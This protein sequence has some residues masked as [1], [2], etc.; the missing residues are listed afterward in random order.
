MT[1][2]LSP[3]LHERFFAVAERRPG[4]PAIVDEHGTATYGELA[5]D[6]V[7][8]RDL[9]LKAA[10]DDERLIA[11]RAGRTR[12]AIAAMIGILAA[13]RGYVPIDPDYPSARRE[14]L[15][16]DSGTRL[17]LTDAPGADARLDSW[18]GLFLEAV[19]R[20]PSPSVPPGTA[21]VIYTSG[22]TGDPK[23]CVV[24]HDNVLALLDASAPLFA[25]GPGDV[26][27]VL[28]SFSFDF[29]VWEIWAALLF[30]GTAVLLSRSAL[31]DPRELMGSLDD[32]G[33]TRLSATPSLF[34]FLVRE[35]ETRA[36]SLPR[37]RSVV[38]GGEPIVPSDVASWLDRA[39]APRA[40]VVNMY[41][42]TETTVHVTYCRLDAGVLAEFDEG[43]PIGRPLPHLGISLRS[44]DGRPVGPGQAGEIWVSG[45]G[46][47]R[48]YLDRPALTAE[49]FRVDGDVRYYVSGDWGLQRID[50]SFA[51]VGRRDR[52]AKVRG[53]RIELGEIEA[54]L[55]RLDAVVD[56]VCDI[57]ETPA[58]GR[59]I[60]G[61]VVEHEPLSDEWLR[62][63][64]GA[65]LPAHMVPHRFRRLDRIPLTVNGK[66][67]RAALRAA[68]ERP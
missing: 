32:L 34:S 36:H 67:D 21:Y 41:G 33:V 39:V 7:G 45:T 11:L 4:H 24:G 16:S 38:L 54:A 12:T 44:E 48:G 56:A 6:A 31:A 62:E 68:R 66:L 20:R 59:L 3:T 15:L 37:L 57:E 19:E 61:H 40:D 30:G 55:R 9:V 26:W 52:Q 35:S 23:G 8:L 10:R 2:P 25:I 43:T 49:R 22:S 65:E 29:S 64:L 42:I 13:G 17:T 28:H 1:P 51:Y 63:Q 58:G 60:V 14:Y 50:G 53:Y 27:S 18:G 47:S 46:V 5:A